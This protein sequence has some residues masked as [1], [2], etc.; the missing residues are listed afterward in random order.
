MDRDPVYL[1]VNDDNNRPVNYEFGNDNSIIAETFRRESYKNKLNK[2][3]CFIIC[4]GG[5]HCRNTRDIPLS[6]VLPY[7]RP[8]P[9]EIVR[10][11]MDNVS[12]NSRVD[13]FG[14]HHDLTQ[15]YERDS[16][17]FKIPEPFVG[18]LCPTFYKYPKTNI[19]IRNYWFHGKMH[20]PAEIRSSLTSCMKLQ[21]N[22]LGTD[23]EYG[24]RV[25]CNYQFDVMHGPICI[26]TPAMTLSG[27][28]N[29]GLAQ[30]IYSIVIHEDTRR[31]RFLDQMTLENVTSNGIRYIE[32]HYVTKVLTF[33]GR[34][35]PIT[36]ILQRNYTGACDAQCACHEFGIGI[37]LEKNLL[38]LNSSF[39]FDNSGILAES[40]KTLTGLYPSV[41]YENPNCTLYNW[42]LS[43]FENEFPKLNFYF[44]H[45]NLCDY[46]NI[47]DYIEVVDRIHNGETR[48][49]IPDCR[50][51]CYP[52]LRVRRT[53]GFISM[54]PNRLNYITTLLETNG[55][56]FNDNPELRI[57]SILPKP[58]PFDD[59]NE[60]DWVS[61]LI[62]NSLKPDIYDWGVTKKKVFNLTV[63]FLMCILLF[64]LMI[65]VESQ[66]SK[67]LFFILV[68]PVGF[69]IL[70][71]A[72]NF[73]IKRADGSCFILG[74]Q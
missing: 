65:M 5:G 67:D 12:G 36:M 10:E 34:R 11:I 52:G 37:N 72:D 27:E 41:K 61:S 16:E 23:L 68:I 22:H 59:D 15:T 49:M 40:V 20:G 45:E 43:F 9:I 13:M 64:V 19:F 31:H 56:M 35:Y 38:Y 71:I 74:N 2:A 62:P 21:L 3:L 6:P 63:H 8:L 7:N 30:G 54:E 26:E 44:P 18:Q 42:H 53:V 39:A 46:R 73:L 51:S 55:E 32:L 66:T 48:P 24:C 57:L 14:L 70:V 50:R 29:M 33:E 1:H 4:V 17:S 25:R 58:P 28:L 69:L 47:H 60:G